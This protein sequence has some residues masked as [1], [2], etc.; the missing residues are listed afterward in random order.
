MLRKATTSTDPIAF[1]RLPAVR[2]RTGLSRATIY[3]RVLVGEFPAPINLGAR[4]VGWIDRDI[5]AWMAA[6]VAA[7]RRNPPVRTSAPTDGAAA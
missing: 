6:R 2:A 7:G 4:A 1:L 5:A 3:A